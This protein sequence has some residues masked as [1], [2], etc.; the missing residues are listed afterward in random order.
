MSSRDIAV[1]AKK[2][3][4][5][6]A[7]P[8]A[9]LEERKWE[10][11]VLLGAVY[12]S[13]T[14]DGVARANAAREARWG[15]AIRKEG[16]L[17]AFHPKWQLRTDDGKPPVAQIAIESALGNRAR[18]LRVR[19]A[20][21]QLVQPADREPLTDL[22]RAL[23]ADAYAGATGPARDRFIADS[24]RLA[25]D[26][27]KD[28]W[29][30]ILP[31]PEGSPPV[32]ILLNEQGATHDG[33]WHD[34]PTDDTA[35]EKVKFGWKDAVRTWDADFLLEN[36]LSQLYLTVESAAHGAADT[37]SLAARNLG[38]V[39]Q[40]A[41]YALGGLAVVGLTAALVVGLRRIA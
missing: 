2:I 14:P 17:S 28:P 12:A 22:A 16:P 18:D 32:L 27:F 39:L 19:L 11:L 15:D 38:L 13:A 26:W 31:P 29:L 20:A 30:T 34:D 40:W 21:L 5:L 35:W 6:A 3:A 36:P 33:G 4:E 7:L 8:P 1:L 41:P 37:T 25:G 24:R 9:A 10:A 23:V